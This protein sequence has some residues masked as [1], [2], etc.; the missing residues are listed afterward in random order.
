MRG[1]RVR[2]IADEEEGVSGSIGD[3]SSVAKACLPVYAK[4]I[5]GARLRARE[6]G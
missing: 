6:A 2:C 4:E 1:G 5:R 3:G